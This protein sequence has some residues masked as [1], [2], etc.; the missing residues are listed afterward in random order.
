MD[1]LGL[2]RPSAR[3]DGSCDASF[4]HG[5]CVRADGSGRN[6]EKVKFLRS[7]FHGIIRLNDD[8][9]RYLLWVEGE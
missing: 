5:S 7:I 8:K 4:F 3:L 1:C 2:R 6:P 9:G